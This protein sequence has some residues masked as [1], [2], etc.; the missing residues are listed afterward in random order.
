MVY[1]SNNGLSEDAIAKRHAI[2]NEILSWF[3]KA[4]DHDDTHSLSSSHTKDND[5]TDHFE[6]I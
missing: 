4:H 6:S 2:E 5:T 1:S 3:D